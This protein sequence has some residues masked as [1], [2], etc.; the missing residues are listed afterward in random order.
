[1]KRGV[2]PSWL[3]LFGCGVLFVSGETRDIY[4][5]W[6]NHVG[7]VYFNHVFGNLTDE[8]HQLLRIDPTL[9]AVVDGRLLKVVAFYDNE[10]GYTNQLLRV[11]LVL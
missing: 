5:K 7:S 1:M 6:M 9:T 2:I 8:Q 11:A 4:R 10:W 3:L